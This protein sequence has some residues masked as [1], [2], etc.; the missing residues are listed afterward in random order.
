MQAFASN[1]RSEDDTPPLKRAIKESHVKG[2]RSLCASKGKNRLQM[3][4]FHT[5][6]EAVGCGLDSIKACRCCSMVVG[7][8]IPHEASILRTDNYLNVKTKQALMS[9][10]PE[11]L[12]YRYVSDEAVTDSRV[13]MFKPVDAP[14]PL[15]APYVQMLISVGREI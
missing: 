12:P 10:V 3:E 9:A 6:P 14:V 8:M 5:K 11:L 13:G 1:Q 7:K 15:A 2:C 4:L